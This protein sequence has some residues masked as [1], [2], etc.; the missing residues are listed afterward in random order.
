MKKFFYALLAICIFAS[1]LLFASCGETQSEQGTQGSQNNENNKNNNSDTALV[2]IEDLSEFTVVRGENASAD[3]KTVAVKLRK[4]LNSD[5]GAG[6]KI[7]TD[8]DA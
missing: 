8:Y 6:V 1:T 4:T 7:A 3:E 2:A 5:F